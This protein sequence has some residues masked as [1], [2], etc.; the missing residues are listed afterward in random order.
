MVHDTPQ[1]HSVCIL[2]LNNGLHETFYFTI[3]FC[4]FER[5]FLGL[6]RLKIHKKL[7][8]FGKIFCVSI[9]CDLLDIHINN[10][11]QQLWKFLRLTVVTT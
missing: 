6:F 8:H 1:V 3:R 11:E 10:M 7:Y 5:L 2:K 9:Y 4:N